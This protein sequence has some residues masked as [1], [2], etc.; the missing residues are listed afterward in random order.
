MRRIHTCR[1]LL[2]AENLKQ[3][4]QFRFSIGAELVEHASLVFVHRSLH[5]PQLNFSFCG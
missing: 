5:A 3:A 2:T 1:Y 4:R